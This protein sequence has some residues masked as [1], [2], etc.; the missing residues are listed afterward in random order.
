VSGETQK[1]KR[2]LVEEN[3]ALRRRLARLE[4]LDETA[5]RFDVASNTVAYDHVLEAAG[6]FALE[7]DERFMIT[8]ATPSIQAALGYTPDEVIHRGYRDWVHE[9]DREHLQERFVKLM[10]SG[11]SEAISC[12]LRHKD[13]QCKT[14]KVVACSYR[15]AGGDLNLVALVRDA[16]DV[17]QMDLSLRETRERNQLVNE[18]SRDVVL[19]IT[20]LD[21]ELIWANSGLTNLWGYTA[22]DFKTEADFSE[23]FHP[24]DRERIYSNFHSALKGVGDICDHEP[25]RYRHKDGSYHWYEGDDRLYQ[26]ETGETQ[27]L[28]VVRDVSKTQRALE[29]LRES[30]ERYRIL[31]QLKHDVILQQSDKNGRVIWANSSLY[32]VLG[33]TKEE[34]TDV[35]TQFSNVHPDDLEAARAAYDSVYPEVGTIIRYPIIRCRHKD[36]SWRWLDGI[37]MICEN[38][39]GERSMLSASRDVTKQVQAEEDRRVLAERTHESQRLESLGVMAGGIAHDFNNLLTPIVGETSLALGDLEPESALRPQLLRIQKAA[40]RAAALTNQMLA[41]SGQ[42]ALLIEPINLSLLVEEM[43]ELLQSNISGGAALTYSLA[44]DLPTIEG[45]ASQL[46]QIVMNLISNARESV[47]DG[48]GRIA[49]RTGVMAASE[50]KKEHIV[51]SGEVGS[52]LYVFLDVSDNGCGMEAETTLRIFDPFFSTKFTGRGLGLASVTGIVRGHRGLI[53]LESEVGRGTKFQVLL[54]AAK[55]YNAVQTGRPEHHSP[56]R[57]DGTVL[58]MDDEEGVRELA[59]ATL[60]RAGF[61]VLL[62]SDGREGLELFHRHAGEI[63]AVVLDRTM[64]DISGDKVFEEIRRTQPD[65]VVI[66]M[67]GYS[68]DR[69]IAQIG[70][71]LDAFL[72]KPFEPS[73][74]VDIVRR[75]VE[76]KSK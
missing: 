37:E 67:S 69:A 24:D 45:D 33:Y 22:D 18:M 11:D 1:T 8:H 68:E 10:A 15:N 40:H 3:D 74:L 71:H 36:G 47:E 7:L 62:A 30:E 60:Q 9:E 34:L 25:F 46:S 26:T 38:H 20:N 12:R 72:Q 49:I 50:V 61:R 29:D 21:G 59:E 42:G 51:G 57:S 35:E 27:I 48:H 65:A 44:K 5:A 56:W 23:K 2:E 58:V 28:C 75:A 73:A 17:S 76:A 13:G 39:R 70:E 63:R 32:D 16:S 6:A 66:L 52:D 4:A 14:F 64:P 31:D 43:G 55:G 41:Y 19:L 54:P 53:V